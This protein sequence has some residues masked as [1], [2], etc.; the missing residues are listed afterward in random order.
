V[1]RRPIAAW[2]IGPAKSEGSSMKIVVDGRIV[3]VTRG[4]NCVSIELK[5]ERQA[6]IMAR[7]LAA[8][9]VNHGYD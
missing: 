3:H 8:D 7:Q 6:L 9:R 5:D 2:A 1:R 4:P